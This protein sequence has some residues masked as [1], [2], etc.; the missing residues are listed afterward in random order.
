M[1]KFIDLTGKKFGKLTVVSRNADK[2]SPCGQ[3]RTTWNCVC[4]C[5]NKTIVSSNNLRRGHTN[6][7]GCLNLNRER[8]INLVGMRFGMLEV[9]H[10]EDDYVK[11]SGRKILMWKCRCDCG[12]MV[13]VSGECLR[14]GNTKSCG[15]QRRNKFRTHG[16]SNTRLY[17]IWT[18]MKQR[19]LNSNQKTYKYYGGR[20]ITI[21]QEWINDFMSF[22]DWSLENGYQD[23]LTIDRIDVNGG[24]EPNNC[25]WV[26]RETQLR[27]TRRNHFVEING[28]S[29]TI[30]EWARIYEINPQTINSRVRKGISEQDAILIPVKRKRGIK[31]EYIYPDKFQI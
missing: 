29:H 28:E 6:S 27:N 13:T 7:C 10:R 8:F 20:G 3:R 19:C 23:K 12:N 5:G 15:C 18:D 31:R 4:D 17:E 21:C 16:K 22:Y 11:P 26:T 25:R 2:I 1:G 30:A 14:H 9:L 24:Y